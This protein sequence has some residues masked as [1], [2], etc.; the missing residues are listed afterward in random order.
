MWVRSGCLLSLVRMPT[1]L[2]NPKGNYI[3]KSRQIPTSG[4][5]TSSSAHGLI[6]TPGPVLPIY[7][8]AVIE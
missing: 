7:V 1:V 5:T 4:T 8:K 3:G 6:R 2:P